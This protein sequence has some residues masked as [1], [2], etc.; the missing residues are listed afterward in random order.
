MAFVAFFSFLSNLGL[1]SIVVREIVKCNKCYSKIIGTTFFLKFLGG[2]L[3]FL[4]GVVLISI[5]RADDAITQM[6]VM[7]LLLGYIFQSMDAVNYYFE[8]KVMSKYVV[9]A[10]NGAFIFSSILKIYLI[11]LKYSIIYFAFAGLVDI[12]LSS[13]FIFILYKKLGFRVK[14]WKIDVSLVKNLLKDS[15]SLMLSAFFITIYM[16]IDQVMIESFLDMKS[17]GLYSVAVR[18]SEAW[19]FVPT[20]IVSTLMPYFIKIRD[21][22]KSLYIYRLKQ[23]NTL[24]FWMSI[25]VGVVVT[26]FGQEMIVLMFGEVYRD[27][28]AALALNIWAGVFVSIGL[29]TSLWLIVE[30]LQ[31]YR[32]IGTM[33][34]VVLNIMGNYILIPVYGISGAAVSTLIT[35]GIGLWIAPLFF[36]PIRKFT[37]MSFKSI[38]PIYLI[39]GKK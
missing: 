19:Y 17:V 12:V 3:A 37:I 30:N 31:I 26:L 16:K 20:I 8:A 32:L 2:I 21:T 11:L 22:D 39:K 1:N 4:L 15:W 34:S 28:Y 7:I 27:A 24:M 6:I 5:Y 35:Q 13:I 18:L 9:F 10:R 38:L 14:D 23:I 25:G 36:K 33:I 29:A